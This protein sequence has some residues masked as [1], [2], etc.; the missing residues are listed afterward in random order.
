LKNHTYYCTVSQMRSLSAD[1][2]IGDP[3]GGPAYGKREMPVAPIAMGA[4]SF[5][6]G[7]AAF[8][9]GTATF[10]TGLS[11]AASALS[12]VGAV[13]GNKTLAMI[14]GV[15][16]LG[17]GLANGFGGA[18]DAAGAGFDAAAEAGEL[19]GGMT[20]A[21][22]LSADQLASAAMPGVEGA[23]GFADVADIGAF[24]DVGG[25]AAGGL[26]DSG[27]YGS[28]LIGSAEASQAAPMLQQTGEAAAQVS[29]YSTNVQNTM[30]T[31]APAGPNAYDPNAVISADATAGQAGGGLIGSAQ[32][33]GG[34]MDRIGGF[35]KNNP[36]LTKMVVDTVG[37]LVPNNKQQAETEL[38]KAQAERIRNMTAEEKQRQLWRQGRTS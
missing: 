3:F 28:G 15:M 2:P 38:T 12:I 21:A 19:V 10:M 23:G 5:M 25:G 6:S 1:M 26:M 9:A 24:S 31:A 33:G 22:A 27:G 8:A 20:D 16:S 14:G 32:A 30:T 4:M 13:T 7:A 17:A 34:I 11:M 36:Q 37:G 29:P 18:A 35:V